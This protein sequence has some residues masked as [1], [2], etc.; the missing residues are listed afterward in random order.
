MQLWNIPM[1][2]AEAEPDEVETD[3]FAPL[4]FTSADYETDRVA[5]QRLPMGRSSAKSPTRTHF[6]S[7]CAKK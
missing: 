6:G 1:H 5:G 7:C 4:K 2:L 3:V